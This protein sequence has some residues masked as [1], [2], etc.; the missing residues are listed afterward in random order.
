MPRS[1]Q[2]R[3]SAFDAPAPPEVSHFGDAGVDLVFD[4]NVVEDVHRE[5]VK[6]AARAI[7]PRLKRAAEDIFVIGREL[8]GVRE[9]LPYGSYVDWLDVEFGLSVRQAYRFISVAERLSGKSF[10]IMS[11]LPPTTLY[12][13]AAPSTPDQAIQAIEAKVIAGEPVRVSTV[14]QAI[15]QARQEDDNGQDADGEDVANDERVAASKKLAHLLDQAI[16]LLDDTLLSESEIAS[17]QPALN[18]LRR[19]LLE[20]TA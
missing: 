16:V 2:R 9:F 19:T 4:Y 8:M 13:L 18:Q 3:R 11:K 15:A 20:R 14:R 1:E 17:V 10:D 7:K 12:M 5:L 6:A